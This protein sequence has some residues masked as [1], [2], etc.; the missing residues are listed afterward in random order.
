MLKYLRPSCLCFCIVDGSD[1][2]EPHLSS[3]RASIWEAISDGLRGKNKSDPFFQRPTSDE[4]Y[5]ALLTLKIKNVRTE[6]LKFELEIER[7][8]NELAK[9][10]ESV[11]P[12]ARVV[13]KY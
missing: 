8:Q 7:L 4:L 6:T 2:Q 11:E 5:Y 3:K 1:Q 10:G 9:Q 12:A 13:Y